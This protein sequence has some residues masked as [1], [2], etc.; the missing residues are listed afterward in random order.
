VRRTPSLTIHVLGIDLA[1]NIFQLHGVTPAGRVVLTRRLRRE[2]LLEV[3]AQ[4][5]PCLIGIEARSGA[6]YCQ[7]QFEHLAT[8]SGS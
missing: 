2:R 6:F 8:R 4:I 7:R 5:K 3:V 1:K